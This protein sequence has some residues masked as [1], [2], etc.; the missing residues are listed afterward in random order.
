MKEVTL[1]TLDGWMRKHGAFRVRVT[2]Y[3][4]RWIVTVGDRHRD[5]TGVGVRADW[6]LD[7]AARQW[8]RYCAEGACKW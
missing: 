1:A 7:H 4:D 8:C 3:R 5:I 2:D 6:A